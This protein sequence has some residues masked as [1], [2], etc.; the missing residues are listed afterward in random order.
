MMLNLLLSI[1][2]VATPGAK[3][4]PIGPQSGQNH[5]ETSQI[6][7]FSAT[8]LT[9]G[10]Y[11]SVSNLQNQSTVNFSLMPAWFASQIL[12][13][14]GVRLD[15]SHPTRPPVWSGDWAN[16]GMMTGQPAQLNQPFNS[17]R[18]IWNAKIPADTAVEL[19]IRA[20]KDGQHWTLWDVQTVNGGLA[21]FEQSS[22]Y[23]YVQYRAR[24]FSKTS[25]TSP[26][27]EGVQLT[28]NVRDVSSLVVANIAS[29]APQTA[30]T[31]KVYATREGLV[32]GTTANGH[33]IRSHDHFV[34][35]PGWTALNDPGK[36]DYQVRITTS[37]GISAVAPVWDV[38]PWNFHDDY[39]HSPRHEFKDLPVG[40]PEA[41]R[42]VN[43]YNGGLNE[44]GSPVYMSSGIDI[45]DGTF[46]D[47]LKLNNASTP[48]RISV[49]FLWE[50][51][52]PSPPSTPAP[53]PTSPPAPP[54]KPTL[55]GV[56]TNSIGSNTATFKWQTST[57]ANG[58][59]EYG[60]SGNYD[61]FSP[62]NGNMV[63]NH[64]V[65]VFDL[66][67]NHTYHFRVHSHDNN[68]ELVSND[69]TFLTTGGQ[70]APL[71]LWQHDKGIGVEV[72]KQYDSVM[73]A[74]GRIN[75]S[76]WNDNPA[77]DFNAGAT[78][79]V[80][81]VAANGNL[82]FDMT[83]T[84][85]DKGQNCTF[86]FGSGYK[87]YVQFNN[88]KGDIVRVGLIHGA[89]ISPNAGTL[90][91]EGVVDG[92]SVNQY[93]PADTVDITRP[94]HLHL[95]WFNKQLSIVFD[96]AAHP[97]SVTVAGDSLQVTFAG[98]ARAKDD[99]VAT[100]FQHIAFGDGTVI[101]K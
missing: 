35:L 66:T 8:N 45:A 70:T 22:A 50:G 63:T 58:W 80:N 79:P 47:D 38:G 7:A 23:R 84:C 29:A 82:D 85:N 6:I 19:D 12:G 28:A 55:S 44:A 13:T 69:A 64:S 60:F 46:W 20:S 65:Q 53:A 32:G 100:T 95:N 5:Q 36:Y 86:G 21:Q 33:V 56:A 41:E 89:G 91:V 1:L 17:I 15:N 37:D 73:V 93:Y 67:P 26:L 87:V 31:F 24:L 99:V 59:V 75:N 81:L 34:S 18:A 78:T 43:G 92:K 48:G 9:G 3:A 101:A 14:M 10:D 27:F 57:A 25:D 77:D 11:S 94:H 98:A 40:V 51:S 52:D 88:Y 90:M 16:F 76:Y 71:N 74:G 97:S 2:L 96:Y 4:E 68:N 72:T 61:Q 30:P 54:A 49:T 39:W 62:I 83:P 42:A